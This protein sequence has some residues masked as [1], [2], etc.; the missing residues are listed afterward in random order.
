MKKRSV[1][2]DFLGSLNQVR[3]QVAVRFPKFDVQNLKK[4]MS[5]LAHYHY[6]KDKFFVIGQ[7]KELYNFLIENSYNP[8]T[9]YR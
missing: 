2:K 7:D 8:Y 9:L 1:Q 6:N 4:I 5:K 3:K